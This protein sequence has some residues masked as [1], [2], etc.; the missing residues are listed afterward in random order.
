MRHPDLPDNAAAETPR[1]AFEAVYRHR[2]WVECEQPAETQAA[3]DAAVAGRPPREPAERDVTPAKSGGRSAAR[4][5]AGP[6]KDEE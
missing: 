3:L 4:G 1:A 6:T 2:G 5:K